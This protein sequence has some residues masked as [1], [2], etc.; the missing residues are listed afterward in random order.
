MWSCRGFL[1]VLK[2]SLKVIISHSIFAMGTFW[3]SVEHMWNNAHFTCLNEWHWHLCTIKAEKLR[4][5][6]DHLAQPALADPLTQ[7]Y[8]HPLLLYALIS[9]LSRKLSI[10]V[11]DEL[12][13]WVCTTLWGSKFHIFTIP[14]KKPFLLL[15]VLN[16]TPLSE[17]VTL[18]SRLLQKCGNFQCNHLTFFPRKY[19]P[20]LLK[21]SS[22]HHPR[23]KCCYT[24]SMISIISL[25]K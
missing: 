17:A 8:F 18:G 19:K 10:S 7:S 21:L 20:Y 24:P 1:P 9:F 16:G 25:H 6:I 5:G 22:I 23:I 12:N 11:L 14:S 15:R 3:V 13:D 2:V 4:A